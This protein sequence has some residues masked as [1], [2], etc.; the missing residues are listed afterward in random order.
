MEVDGKF[1]SHRWLLDQHFQID[2]NVYVSESLSLD[3][4]GVSDA[5]SDRELE[6]DGPPG[7]HQQARLGPCMSVILKDFSL[8][9]MS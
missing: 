9:P 7:A 2:T 4:P 6:W 1:Q 3:S 5:G 8:L